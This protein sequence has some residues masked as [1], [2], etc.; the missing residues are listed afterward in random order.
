[1]SLLSIF[2]Q[3]ADFASLLMHICLLHHQM[4][5]FV[6]VYLVIFRIYASCA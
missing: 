1:M 6:G 2:M 3:I 4:P 5:L